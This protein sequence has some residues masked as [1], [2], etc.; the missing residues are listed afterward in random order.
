MRDRKRQTETDRERQ[1]KWNKERRE[2]G[3]RG[4]CP[5]VGERAEWNIS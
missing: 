3:R 1:R 4:L 2:R 5:S